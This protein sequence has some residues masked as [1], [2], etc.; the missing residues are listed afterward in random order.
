MRSRPASSQRLYGQ[1]TNFR[2]PRI[3][4]VRRGGKRAFAS[5]EIQIKDQKF[6]EILKSAA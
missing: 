6:L 2:T 4:G 3:M 5:L 1:I